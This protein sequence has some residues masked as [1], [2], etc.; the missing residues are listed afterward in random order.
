VERGQ[1]LRDIQPVLATR[2]WAAVDELVHN[3]AI[4]EA[5]TGECLDY[6]RSTEANRPDRLSNVELPLE[7]C[8]R[9]LG[10]SDD[11]TLAVDAPTPYGVTRT[12]MRGPI[13][14][15]CSP[16]SEDFG[17][18][19]VRNNPIIANRRDGDRVALPIRTESAI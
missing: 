15:D 14:L 19:R 17:V 3:D 9:A 2:R 1:A 8:G 16:C 13:Q 5:F 18:E 4:A 10:P 11:A 7:G 12:S 6:R